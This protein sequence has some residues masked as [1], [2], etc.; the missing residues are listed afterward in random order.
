[1]GCIDICAS[2]S[3]RHKDTKQFK[4]DIEINS[5]CAVM[6]Y[7]SIFMVCSVECLQYPDT[8]LALLLQNNFEAYTQNTCVF[9]LAV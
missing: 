4:S 8:M 7:K 5:S 2:A 6:P 1:M 9:L 3:L